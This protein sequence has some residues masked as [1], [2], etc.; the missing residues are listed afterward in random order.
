MCSYKL[1]TCV[2]GN[3]GSCLK[4]VKPLVVYDGA[5]GIVLKP[6]QGIALNLEWI[7]ATPRYFTFLR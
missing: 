1:K 5:H 3:F 4:Q 2:L 7:W 6:M